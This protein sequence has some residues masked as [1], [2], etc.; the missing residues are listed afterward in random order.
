MFFIELGA[1]DCLFQSNKTFFEFY[2]KGVFIEP[3]YKGY[4]LCKK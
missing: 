2:K 4:L 3:S 1:N